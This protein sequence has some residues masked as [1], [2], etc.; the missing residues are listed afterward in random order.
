MRLSQV[1]VSSVDLGGAEWF[2]L[3]LGL[4][5]IVGDDR[6]LRFEYPDG[7]CTFSVGL[8]GERLAGER[9]TV[10]FFEAD[11]LG[12]EAARLAVAGIAWSRLRPPVPWSWRDARLRD[13]DGHRLCFCR[14]GR[15]RAGGVVPP[16]R[17]C[18]GER[19][20]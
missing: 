12:A 6:Y 18:A 1:T 17:R 3:T 13:P 8:V 4:R 7:G 5:L 9:V 2:C 15:R 10:Y 11:D 20:S 19:A 16:A 14:A